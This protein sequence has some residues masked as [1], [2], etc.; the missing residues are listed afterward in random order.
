M[1]LW[2]QSGGEG[3]GADDNISNCMSNNDDNIDNEDIKSNKI[4]R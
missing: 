2:R 4:E 1:L 3:R